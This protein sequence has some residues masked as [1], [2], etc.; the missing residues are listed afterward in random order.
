MPWH[1]EPYTVG[2]VFMSAASIAAA[3]IAEPMYAV[4]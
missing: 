4:A 1:I 3:L 2:A